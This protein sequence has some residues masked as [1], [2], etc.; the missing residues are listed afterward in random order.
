V[1]EDKI[2]AITKFVPFLEKVMAAKKPLLIIAEDVTGEALS[3]LVI[4]KLRGVLNV[5]AVKAPG[6]GDRRKAM[7][8]DIAV[9]T[10]AEPIMKDL[11][12]ELDQIQ[13]SQLGMA[14]RSRSTTTTPRSSRARA[15][16]RRSRIASSRSAARSRRRP[17]T[18]TARSCRSASPSLPAAWP[19][20]RSA[21][22]QRSRAQGEEGP[23]RGRAAR[24]PRGHRRGHRSRRRRQLPPFDRRARQDTQERQGGRAVGVD[25][26]TNALRLPLQ[27]IAANAGEKGTV[28]VSKVIEMARQ[29][30]G[31]DA[32]N[33]EYGD[34]IE[35][36]IITPAKVDRS[37]L[38]NA[39]SVTSLLLTA[40]CIVTEK[41]S[42]GD[43]GGP[44]G[45]PG[46]DPMG[47]MGGMGGMACGM[48][49]MGF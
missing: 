30:Q 37:A 31:Y 4:N 39:A 1:Y 18:T 20:S 6:Y 33:R 22:C 21:R 13:L 23:R 46:M 32:L 26:V 48:G 38:Q 29:L 9:L 19:R 11:G 27:T 43:A 45:A 12:V 34:L 41:P 42:D 28:I 25:I 40:D 10:G 5:A 49:G 16:P 47:G 17:A 35:K 36:G 15:S 7:L 44:G 14:K 2:D 24:D 8:Q 3:T